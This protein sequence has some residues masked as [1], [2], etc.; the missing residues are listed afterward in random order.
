[1]DKM[2]ISAVANGS[3]IGV[4]IFVWIVAVS[5]HVT[6]TT[7]AISLAALTVFI[8]SGLL[9]LYYGIT[10]KIEQLKDAKKQT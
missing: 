3:S 5:N 2:V 4:I 7:M 1:M 8:G 10:Q 9:M 6:V